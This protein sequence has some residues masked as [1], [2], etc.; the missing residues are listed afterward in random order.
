MNWMIF[1]PLGAMFSVFG[2]YMLFYT[3]TPQNMRKW[4]INLSFPSKEVVRN[5]MRFS[6][7]SMLMF[8]G[9]GWGMNQLL[10]LDTH[11]LYQSV[12]E[13]GWMYTI[14][15]LPLMFVLH[16]AWFY[17]SHRLLHM[18]ILYHSVHSWHH[19]FDN[20]TPFAAYAFH[21][22]EALM[23]IGILPLMMVLFPVHENVF[24]GYASFVLF[25]TAYGHLGFEL[26]PRKPKIFSIFNTGVHHHQH[27]Q[28]YHFNYS[29]YMNLWDRWMGTNHPT[30]PAAHEA[31]ADER[32]KM[33][34]KESIV[35]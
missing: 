4:K 14:L 28:Y 9:V 31:F 3:F 34:D 17:W 30:Y 21:P 29:L 8:A 13:M 26:R 16:D 22:V 23:Q 12:G 15:S 11:Q 24:I 7:Y 32:E 27:H 10:S 5:E 1:L 33:N 25:M 20:P 6:F 18:D 35:V 2:L 19:T